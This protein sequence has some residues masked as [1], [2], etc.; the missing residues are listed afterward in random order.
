M[1]VEFPAPATVLY[2]A[3]SVGLSPRPSTMGGGLHALLPPPLLL[4]FLVRLPTPT[5]VVGPTRAAAGAMAPPVVAAVPCGHPS[6][7]PGP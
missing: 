1:D 2:D 4:E 5:G 6:T 7:T 3:S